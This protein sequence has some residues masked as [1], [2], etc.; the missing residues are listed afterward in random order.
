MKML[1]DYLEKDAPKG[2]KKIY[3]AEISGSV[4]R[5]KIKKKK[6]KGYHDIEEAIEHADN[7]CIREVYKEGEENNSESFFIKNLR[8]T[9]DL[10]K[11]KETLKIKEIKKI[12]YLG[13]SIHG[14]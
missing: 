8:R 2:C 10:D 3:Y 12:K 5:I 7:F 11:Q 6:K 4:V 13:Y 1:A 14:S 9:L